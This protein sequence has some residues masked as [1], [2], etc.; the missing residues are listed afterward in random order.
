LGKLGII[1]KIISYYLL[2]LDTLF[3]EILEVNLKATCFPSI[4]PLGILNKRSL[5][6]ANI[7]VKNT[8]KLQIYANCS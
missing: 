6:F 7:L 1:A 8:E 5:Y 4:I 3:P 2:L